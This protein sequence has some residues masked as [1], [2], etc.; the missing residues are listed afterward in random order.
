MVREFKEFVM[1]GNLVELAVAFVLALAFAT[2]IEALISGVVLP[3]IAAILGEPNFDALTLNVGD[4]VIR[5][6]TFL[7][8]LVTFLLIA[9]VLFL[10]VRAYNRM[11]RTRE[12][13]APTTKGCGFCLTEIPIAATRCPACTSQVETPPA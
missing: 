12:T 13:A 2:V 7:T 9:L 8:A 1:R 3:L 5:Y 11:T 10:V 6:G 4:G